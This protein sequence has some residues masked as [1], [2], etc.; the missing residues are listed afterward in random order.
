VL[1]DGQDPFNP[2]NRRISIIVMNQH[3]EANAQKDATAQVVGKPGDAT[4][5]AIDGK[6]GTR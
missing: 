3:A 5:E 1:F 6:G 2:I 4:P